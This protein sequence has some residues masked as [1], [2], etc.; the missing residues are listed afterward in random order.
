MMKVANCAD[1]SLDSSLRSVFTCLMVNC[2]R[3]V[4][5]QQ[6]SESC[7]ATADVTF[8]SS[9][10]ESLVSGDPLDG[11][12]IGDAMLEKG[13]THVSSRSLIT[14]VDGITIISRLLKFMFQFLSTC[15]GHLTNLKKMLLRDPND[16]KNS[17][18]CQP[19]C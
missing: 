9:F 2:S 3:H 18:Q 11:G 12:E 14:G 4:S 19:A 17:K 13:E 8:L 7:V 15:Y 1:D 5:L 10:L 6:N 16:L